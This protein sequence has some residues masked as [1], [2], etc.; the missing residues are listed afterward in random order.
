MT[1][2]TYQLILDR[3]RARQETL[4]EE[5]RWRLLQAWRE[6]Y[7]AGLHKAMGRWKDGDFEWNVFCSGHARALNGEKAA[8]AYAQ[9][10]PSA[11]IVCPESPRVPAVQLVGGELPDFRS[12]CADVYVWPEDLAWTMGFTHEESWGLGPY[13]CR[14]EWVGS[15]T[16]RR[17]QWRWS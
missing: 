3:C 15:P 11:V 10:H 7:A 13:F 1:P 17:R 14:R 8:A 2:E 4:S 16:R 6:V 9:E 12:E 5:M